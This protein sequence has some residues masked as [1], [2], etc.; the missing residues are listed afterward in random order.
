MNLLLLKNDFRYRKII[1]IIKNTMRY[2]EF[3]MPKKCMKIIDHTNTIIKV[4]Y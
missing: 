4:S 1:C 2:L 3:E